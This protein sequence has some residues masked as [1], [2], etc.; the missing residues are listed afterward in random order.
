MTK[1]SLLPLL[2]AV[3]CLAQTAPAPGPLLDAGQTEQLATRILQLMESTAV[4]VPGLIPASASVKQSSQLT[5]SGLQRTPRNPALIYQFMSQVKAYLALADSI[6]RPDPFP[7]AA[8]RQFAELREDLQRMQ[9]YFEAVLQSDSLDARKK[10]SDPSDLKHF[11]E[12]NSKTPAPGTSARVVFLGD[13]TTEVW[14]LNEYFTGRDFINRGIAGQTTQQML[15]RFRQ[16][17]AG[18]EP[19]AVVILGGSEDIADGIAVNQIEDN[20]A[21][22]GDLAKAAGIKP[23]FASIL[24]VNDYHKDENPKFE[25]TRVRPPATIAVINRW[26]D[27]YCRNAAAGCIYLNYQPVLVDTSGLMQSGFSDDG[28]VPGA[29]ALRAMSPLALEAINR[30]TGAVDDS[31]SPETQKKRR[32]LFGR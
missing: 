6:P 13:A 21:M 28:L 29:K 19:K 27:D 10:E 11:A 30:A 18:L 9:Q 4:V 23:I 20:L 5:F 25:V 24:P 15:G 17:V 14:R 32:L 1:C 2:V 3:S 16:D 26:M 31:K 7:P 22:M 12:A 8:D